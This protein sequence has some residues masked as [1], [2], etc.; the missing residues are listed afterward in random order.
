MPRF[1]LLHHDHPT[2]HLDLMLE[3]EEMLWT[4][5]LDAIPQADVEHSANRIQNHRLLYLDY[6]GPVSGGR[7]RVTRLDHGEIEWIVRRSDHVAVC[8]IGERLRGRVVLRQVA[9]EH[10]RLRL[11]NASSRE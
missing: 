3:A 7:G 9:D 8:L 2:A 5:R 11:D 1:V 10:W 4:W 6:E